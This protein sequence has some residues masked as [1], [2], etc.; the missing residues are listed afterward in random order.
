MLEVI[1]MNLLLHRQKISLEL[2]MHQP[3]QGYQKLPF[4]QITIS[5]FIQQ[6]KVRRKLIYYMQFNLTL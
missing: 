1:P 5:P 2:P 4:I 6:E 3:R